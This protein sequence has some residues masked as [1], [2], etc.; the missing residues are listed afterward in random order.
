MKMHRIRP[1][2][3]WRFNSNFDIEYPTLCGRRTSVAMDDGDF[4][5]AVNILVDYARSVDREADE[6]VFEQMCRRCFG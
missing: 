6:V 4:A 3:K 2:R 1:G 5:I